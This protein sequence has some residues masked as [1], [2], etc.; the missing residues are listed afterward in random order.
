MVEPKDLL[1]SSFFQAEL[2]TKEK[3]Q[4]V[5][6]DLQALQA[7]PGWIFI[8]RLL[9]LHIDNYAEKILTDEQLS[10][11][12]ERACKRE[13]SFFLLFKTLPSGL[14]KDLM[15]PDLKAKEEND[16]PFS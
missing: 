1:T 9:K 7:Q 6:M 14:V 5:A 4:K 8:E 12:D 10:V 13:R 11:E 2:N 3:I 16:D 15:N